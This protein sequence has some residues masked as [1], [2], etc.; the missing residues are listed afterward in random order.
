[1]KL[2]RAVAARKLDDCKTL[3][4]KF[5]YGEERLIESIEDRFPIRHIH[6]TIWSFLDYK[7]VFQEDPK[8]KL[9]L[10]LAAKNGYTGI[11]KLLLSV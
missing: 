4:A 5:I 6:R 1:M 3:L 11:T 9:A 2:L 7:N 10:I 8:N